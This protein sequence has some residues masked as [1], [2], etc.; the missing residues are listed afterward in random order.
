MIPRRNITERNGVQVALRGPTFLASDAIGP[1]EV[2]LQNCTNA[3]RTIAF[4]VAEAP[5]LPSKARL[6]C[7][8]AGPVE[9]GPSEVKRIVL[10]LCASA[11]ARGSVRAYLKA[12]ISGPPGRRTRRWRAP[13]LSAPL[14]L[15]L[16]A[17]ATILM[18]PFGVLLIVLRRGGLPIQITASGPARSFED[19]PDPS[20]ESLWRPTTS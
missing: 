2:M 15:P 17:V 11:G 8:D 5:L 1:L 16:I 4:S 19:L 18:L 6:V 12:Q 20:S 13:P 9:L 3:P 10:P 14:G 7:R